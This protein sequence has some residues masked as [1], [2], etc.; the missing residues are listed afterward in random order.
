MNAMGVA[1]ISEGTVLSA[2]TATP[3]DFCG[4]R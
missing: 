4:E 1:Q 2:R 3:S